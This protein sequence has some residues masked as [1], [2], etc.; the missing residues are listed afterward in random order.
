M[1][2]VTDASLEW[3]TDKALDRVATRIDAIAVGTGTR[4][5]EIGI[6]AGGAGGGGTLVVI[7]QF[8]DITVEDGHT[9][10]FTVPFDPSR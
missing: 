1:V 3:Q 8:A 9:E 10:E 7:D 2:T 4:I 6:F 5:S